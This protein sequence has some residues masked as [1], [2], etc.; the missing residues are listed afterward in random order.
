M[1]PQTQARVTEAAGTLR[2]A[3][4]R[5]RTGAAAATGA[6]ADALPTPTVTAVWLHENL[7]S[8]KV[9]D[10]SW[11][12]PN[13]NRDAQVLPHRLAVRWVWP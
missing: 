1:Q 9:I 11:F 12:M 3:L 13:A 8:V 7:S 6:T 4:R 10:A 5:A 2:R